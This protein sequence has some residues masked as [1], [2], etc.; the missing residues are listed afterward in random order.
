MVP[1]RRT[2][3][4]ARNTRVAHGRASGPGGHQLMLHEL[5][6]RRS[7]EIA[8]L[9]QYVGRKAQRGDT[10][11][12][13]IGSTSPEAA[14]GRA[15]TG[16]ALP[17]AVRDL[18]DAQERLD[19]DAG[20]LIQVEAALGVRVPLDLAGMVEHSLRATPPQLGERVLRARQAEHVAEN[21]ALEQRDWIAQ[22]VGFDISDEF[23]E[24][25]AEQQREFVG[26]RVVRQSRLHVRVLWFGPRDLQKGT[27]M[28]KRAYR[29]FCT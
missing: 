10:I 11:R 1:Q 21:L 13:H 7:P 4:S 24:L 3:G 25:G 9:R 27:K 6:P 28:L 19:R 29:N 5:I 20:R 18:L 8:A 23:G 16:C 22:A 12:K 26:Q 15:A 14:R 17:N 2:A